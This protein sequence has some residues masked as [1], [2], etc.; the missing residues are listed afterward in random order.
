MS[1]ADFIERMRDRQA[2]LFS[3]TVNVSRFYSEGTFD[4]DTASYTTPAYVTVYTG[5]ALLRP[6]GDSLTTA[7][8]TST[9]VSSFTLKLPVNT[10]IE[11]GDTVAVTASDFDDGLVGLGL[12]VLDVT[13]D[14]WQIARRCRGVPQTPR[15]T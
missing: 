10:A 15:P 6:D 7:G 11:V 3:T 4:P 1:A 14:E 8:E 13:N 2:A 5:A 9:E 12:R